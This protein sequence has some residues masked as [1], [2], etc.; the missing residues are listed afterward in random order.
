LSPEEV[1]SLVPPKEGYEAFAESMTT[2]YRENLETMRIPGFDPDS[3]TSE[4][5]A[6]AALAAQEAVLA[7]RLALVQKTRRLH[8]SN[9]WRGVLQIYDRGRSAAHANPTIRRAI[10]HFEA[11]MKHRPKKKDVSTPGT[12]NGAPPTTP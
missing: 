1:R 6:A 4:L 7:T 2:L 11:F 12:S 10:A 3:I 9:A 5:S 8:T